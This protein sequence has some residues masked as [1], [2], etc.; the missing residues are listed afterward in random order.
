MYTTIRLVQIHSSYTFF[1]VLIV[2]TFTN[3][4]FSFAQSPSEFVCD[5]NTAVI[6]DTETAWSG[7]SFATP[8]ALKRVGNLLYAGAS[9]SDTSEGLYIYDIS[10]PSNIVQVSFFSSYSP[11]EVRNNTWGNDVVGVDVV[12][13]YAYLTTYQGGLVIVDVSNPALPTFVGKLP[14]KSITSKET[15]DVKVIGSYAYLA[16]GGGL[17]VVD[18]TDKANPVMVVNKNLGA[19]ISHD[20]EVTGNYAYVAMRRNGFSIVDI[21]NPLI[22]TEV[23]RV[24]TGYDINTFAYGVSVKNSVLFVA[25][26]FQERISY[27]DISNPTT[28]V[29][30]NTISVPGGGSPRELHIESDIMYVSGGDGGIYVYD[31]SDPVNPRRLYQ[32]LKPPLPSTAQI[33]GVEPQSTTD[34][35]KLVAVS[36]DSSGGIGVY[37]TTTGCDLKPDL[38]SIFDVTS[39]GSPTQDSTVTLRAS[40][41]NIGRT[42]AGAFSDNFSFSIDNGNSW[43]NINP[44]STHD[45]LAVDD[46]KEDLVSFV[47]TMPGSLILQHCVD[48]Y[49]EI[50]EGTKELPNC[51]QHSI[52]VGSPPTLSFEVCDSDAISGCVLS[53]SGSKVVAMNMPLK[54][55]WNATNV[56][57]CV[58]SGTGFET[59][60]NI[61]GSDDIV[62]ANTVGSFAYTVLCSKDG[63]PKIT[64]TVSIE[65]TSNGG[66]PTL[67]ANKRISEIGGEVM[68]N[69]EVP[70]P[71]AISCTLS[72]GTLNQ[73]VL[74]NG[75]IPVRIYAQTKFTLNCP[76]G[77]DTTTV[78]IVPIGFMS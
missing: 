76:S 77:I 47:P 50:D 7:T 52:T 11:A 45:G 16:A 2:F 42:P 71:A 25:D 41:K 54:A 55:K 8:Q 33:W 64:G 32:I 17:V 3:V 73:N 35:S 63:T 56:D 19:V 48:S 59:S 69:Y 5:A 12:G 60:D 23:A 74:S 31:V 9:G 58:G 67:T 43:V 29:L 36:V 21:S 49:N 57:V 18:I 20:I 78:E 30:I 40:V 13:N 10:D 15:W 24:T 6:N 38:V 1:L 14:L 70:E 44:F 65:T 68:L 46:V 22:P 51:T 62:S 37:T 72:G 39:I 61:A 26:H 53:N 27:Y 34:F 4:S 28:P 75:S 66:I